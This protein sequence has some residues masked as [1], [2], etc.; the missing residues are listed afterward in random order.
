MRAATIVLAFGL[1]AHFADSVRVV[2]SRASNPAEVP[3]ESSSDLDD[4]VDVSESLTELNKT[5]AYTLNM[6]LVWTD[7]YECHVSGKLPGCSLSATTKDTADR[8]VMKS[9]ARLKVIFS[10]SNIDANVVYVYKNRHSKFVESE[11]KPRLE[12]N[13]NRMNRCEIPGLCSLVTDTK[14]HIVVA[15]T[16]SGGL[17][18]VARRGPDARYR[19][20]ALGKGHSVW[21]LA[22]EVGHIFGN[23]EDRQSE[24]ASSSCTSSATFYG[25]RTQDS[26]YRDVMSH[27]CVVGQY[28]CSLGKKITRECQIMPYFGDPALRYL[29]P[30]GTRVP[31]GSATECSACQMRKALPDIVGKM[32]NLR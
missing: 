19:S 31:T 18:G 14:A 32:P 21:T 5:Y 13:M 8:K 17:T 7:A 27:L 1:T 25:Y 6:M 26:R 12:N 3:S 20:V 15:F 9:F 10:N 16:G 30:D 4:L 28:D 23:Y 11:A 22:H 29:A 24:S 2:K